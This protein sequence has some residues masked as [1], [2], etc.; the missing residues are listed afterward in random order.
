M[1]NLV[2]RRAVPNLWS[3]FFGD[4]FKEFDDLFAGFYPSPNKTRGIPDLIS[5]NGHYTVNQTDK[6]VEIKVNIP[7][8]D[9]ELS[10]KDIEV[11]YVDNMLTIQYNDA[12]SDLDVS[13][14]TNAPSRFYLK[15]SVRSSEYDIDDSKIEASLKGNIL[16]VKLPKFQT[17]E[18]KSVRIEVK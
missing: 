10:K 1:Y 13:S 3:G 8:F 16:T 12:N 5:S 4:S 11:S 7:S 2:S 9:E 6:E 15:Y 18:N 14:K 17:I